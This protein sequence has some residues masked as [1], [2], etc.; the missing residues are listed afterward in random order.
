MELARDYSHVQLYPVHLF[1]AIIDDK[2]GIAR[3]LIQK[4]KWDISSLKK[5]LEGL[6]VKLP[7][8][9]PPPVN[10]QMSHALQDIMNKARSLQLQSGDSYISVDTMLLALIEVKEITSALNDAGFRNPMFIQAISDMRG[11]KK[12]T[13]A[14]AEENFEALNKYAIDLVKMAVK[15][16]LDPVI[17]R[18]EEIRRVI[19]VL[20]RRTKNNPVLIGPPGVGKTAIAEGLAQRIA[21]ND[22]PESLKCS[23]F[24]LDMGALI[25]GAKYR[26]EF[27]E[28]LKS[29]LKEIQ[30]A[31]GKIILF[32]DE[33]HL[34]L[35]AGKSDGAMDAA[36]LLKPMLARGELRCIGATT[37]E[38]YRKY[39]EKDAAFER[40]FQPVYVGEPSV[41][42][43]I[44]ILRGL[45]DR[46]ESHH[47]V[48]ISDA[49]L[50]LAAQLAD[51]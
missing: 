16:K 10:Y 36:N 23:L 14:N 30:E 49:A 9:S 6:A 17:G 31:D 21:N 40:R 18:D 48:T 13:Q 15:G 46:Y 32:I 20:A 4:L 39:V 51:R 19:R 50:V 2:E 3:Q 44:S 25:A 27:E 35:G 43:S 26:G 1:I 28:R 7:K 22:V 33:M 8:Q 38:E 12:V 42:D 47:G 37:L 5:A 24:S 41:I 11:S 45:K 29:V 34:I